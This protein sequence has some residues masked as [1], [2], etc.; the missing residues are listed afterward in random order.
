MTTAIKVMLRKCPAMVEMLDLGEVVDIC[1]WTPEDGEQTFYCTTSHQLRITD[2]ECDGPRVADHKAA[3][4]SKRPMP[5]NSIMR[6][7][8]AGT[9][10]SARSR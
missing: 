5:F 3:G 6:V 1:I 7:D 9:Q 2:L 8:E 10:W 4:R